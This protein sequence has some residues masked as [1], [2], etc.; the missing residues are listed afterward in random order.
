[1]V[2][3]AE[4]KRG[5]NVAPGDFIQYIICKQPEGTGPEKPLAERAHSPTEVP[6]SF[7]SPIL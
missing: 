4:K 2:A 5:K 7:S 6:F 3:L 1:M